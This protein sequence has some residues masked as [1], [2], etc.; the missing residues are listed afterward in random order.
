MKFRTLICIPLLLF[1]VGCTALSRDMASKRQLQQDYYDYYGLDYNTEQAA[2]KNA[3]SDNSDYIADRIDRLLNEKPKHDS[4][5][6]KY[7]PPSQR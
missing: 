1:L 2:I 3:P 6:W 7:K 4:A 5:G